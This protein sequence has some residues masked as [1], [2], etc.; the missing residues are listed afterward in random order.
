MRDDKRPLAGENKSKSKF[1]IL[2]PAATFIC[3]EIILWILAIGFWIAGNDVVGGVLAA[4]AVSIVV[5]PCVI[6]GC[7]T[8]EWG[9]VFQWLQYY[10]MCIGSLVHCHCPH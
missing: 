10:F 1:G 6:C 8:G 9:M 5:I 3:V 2:C 4:V 7:I